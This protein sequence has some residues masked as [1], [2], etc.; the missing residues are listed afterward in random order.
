MSKIPSRKRFLVAISLGLAFGVLCAW[1][2]S[3]NDP[4]IFSLKSS[5]FW[6]IVW[7]RFLI[8]LMIAFAGAFVRHP[9]FGFRC[10]PVFRGAILGAIVSLVIAFGILTMPIENVTMIF[11]ATI[12]AGAIYGIIIDLV[13]T[14]VGGEGKELL[15]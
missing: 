15:A 10:F 14:K 3:K 13:A 4:T 9:I 12:G 6:T 5:T 11:W 7:N 1:L 8:G 2:A